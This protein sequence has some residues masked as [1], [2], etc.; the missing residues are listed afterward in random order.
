MEAGEFLRR[1]LL[2]VLPRGFVRIRYFGFCANCR[3]ESGLERI[4][5]LLEVTP[6]DRLLPV[7]P[8]RPEALVRCL[9]PPDLPLCPVCRRGHMRRVELL[10][11]VRARSPPGAPD[12]RTWIS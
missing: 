8:A 6:A 1:F 9:A 11:A 12:S 4:R 7:L 5:R 3:A 2:H 10:P